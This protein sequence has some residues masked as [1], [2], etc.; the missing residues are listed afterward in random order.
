MCCF[1][2]RSDLLLQA[3]TKLLKSTGHAQKSEKTGSLRLVWFILSWIGRHSKL[4]PFLRESTS[5]S[6]PTKESG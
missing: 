6:D 5:T 2:D 3:A 1:P 4:Q